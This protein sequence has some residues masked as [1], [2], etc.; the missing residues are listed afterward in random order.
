[1]VRLNPRARAEA[2]AVDLERHTPGPRGPLHGIP[3]VLKDN[4]DFA[5]MPTTGGSLALAGLMP[6]D[7][8]FQVKKLR[9]AGAIVIGKTNLHELASGILTVGSLLG[10]TRNPY[11]P[12]RNPG[13]SSGGT[14]A[15]VAASF[16]AVGWGSDTCGSIR[17]PASHNN[18]FGLRPTKGL[19]SVDGIL[20]L[21]HTQDVGGPLART[22]TDLAVSLD[23]TVGADP[24][25]PATAVLQGQ[26]LPSFMSA[27][28]AGALRGGR[29]GVLEPF[30]GTEADDRVVGNA[31][32]G[33]LD[34][35]KELGA[36]L[37]PIAFPALDSLNQGAAVID[38]EFKWDLADYLASTPDA[39][40]DSLSDIL[41]RGLIHEALVATMTRRNAAPTRDT[42]AYRT[43]LGRRG[44]LRDA[45]VAVLD[46]ERLDALAYPTVR[47]PPTRIGEAQPG[48]TCSLSA[49]TGLPAL[50][51]PAGFVAG[52]LPVGVELLGRPLADAR[53][54]SLAY[55]YEQSASP[56]RPPFSTPPLVAGQRPGP[57]RFTLDATGAQMEPPVTSGVRATGRFA[58]D[59]AT[60]TLDYD[61]EVAGVRAEEVHGVVV[62]R[63]LSG[64][65]V[66]APWQ[67]VEVLAGPGLLRASGSWALTPQLVERLDA[68]ELYLEVFTRANPAGAARAR[69]QLP[70]S[71]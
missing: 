41:A 17:I 9:A 23:A 70:A 68:G 44:P 28:D 57:L 18:L 43:A 48:S 63:R 60:R 33:A 46:A 8:A 2:E 19:S 54:V 16:A 38:H 55:A 7:D 10:Q 3:V 14:G 53:L 20:P 36:E 25:D 51:I 65:D 30:F 32:R 67:V 12:T 66:T 13:G 34:R 22:V 71:R 42:E 49:N 39:P 35:M 24:A 6:V 29:I 15:A 47:R 26:T 62:R 5:G 4:Y 69:V 37:I 1:M 64:D 40:V 11:D 50:S 27:L 52:G 58:F 21:S 59:R 61:V 56:R 45:V 31:V